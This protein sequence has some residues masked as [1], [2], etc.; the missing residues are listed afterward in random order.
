MISADVKARKS[1]WPQVALTGPER[2][3]LQFQAFP[4]ASQID[5]AY[6][7]AHCVCAVYES[8]WVSGS[9]VC[10]GHRYLGAATRIRFGFV[11]YSTDFAKPGTLNAQIKVHDAL[12]YVQWSKRLSMDRIATI[13]SSCFIW[14]P[15]PLTLELRD[16]GSRILSGTQPHLNH[17]ASK[18]MQSLL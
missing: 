2:F 11:R 3:L 5:L 13:W 14:P 9:N 4:F 18:S 8:G 6:R 1:K 17:I 10:Q 16:A 12:L 7:F 15:T